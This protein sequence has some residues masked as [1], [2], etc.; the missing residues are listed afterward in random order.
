[1]IYAVA[2][3]IGLFVGVLGTLVGAGGGFLLVPILALAEP[4]WATR[5][6]TAFSLAVVAAN[7]TAGGLSYA[8]QQR[9]DLRSFPIFAAA[10]IPGAI[11]G[12][13]LSA[14]VPRAAFD[15]A[16]GVVLLGV[17]IVLFARPARR[18]G[19]GRGSAR[20]VLVDRLG[21]R[22]EWS[23][24]LKLGVAGSAGVGALSSVLGIGGGIVHVPFMVTV[25]GF[26]EH[27]ATATSH[28]VLAVT[29]LVATIVHL[30]HGDFAGEG[31][32]TILVAVGAVIGAP[33]GAR[34]STHLPGRAIT[35]ILALALASVA[36]RLLILG[37][38]NLYA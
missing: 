2:V 35:R 32:L 20:R 31:W 10:A 3:L 26:P 17:A 27:V 23:F 8:R 13:W 22:Y 7:A 25:L 19:S 4:S 5:T 14:Y 16:F 29:A 33:L 38:S 30:A 37:W 15:F 12:A 1:M 9:V 34:L 28:A 36:V 6:V 11:V 21:N 18:A 24:D